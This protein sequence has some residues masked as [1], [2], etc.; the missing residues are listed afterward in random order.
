MRKKEGS[1]KIKINSKGLLSI[2]AICVFNIL[3]ISFAFAAAGGEEAAHP[4]LW[5]DYLWKIINFGVLVFIIYKFGRKP[6]QNFLRNRT[7]LIEKTL[8]EATA[9]KE[10]SQKAL[11]EVEERL[12]MKDEEIEKII[13]AA[14]KSGEQERDRIIE[15]S[16]K[17]R[18]KI[19]EQAKTNIEYELKHA[20]EEIK[21]EAVELAM[22]LAEKKLKEKLTKEEQERLL[23]ESLTK[24]GGRG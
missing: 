10:A 15:Q 2:F 7:E 20:K 6:L 21:A 11:K 19:L 16:S 3:F 1:S 12:R 14:Q 23:E 9:A 17:L 18:E 22:E 4:P 13:S 5:K 24:I 8:N